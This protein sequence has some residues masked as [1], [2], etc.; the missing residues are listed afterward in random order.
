MVLR[1]LP[2]R[3]DKM[4]KGLTRLVKAVTEH[5]SFYRLDDAAAVASVKNW[6]S[7]FMTRYET[8]S[9]ESSFEKS[10]LLRSEKL[11]NLSGSVGTERLIEETA[12]LVESLS[13]KRRLSILD[14]GAEM[15]M[16]PE[17]LTR[18]AAR[19]VGLEVPTS[20]GDV[21]GE[22]TRASAENLQL[23]L[24]EK[25]EEAAS[26]GIDDTDEGKLREARI[27]A[28]AAKASN[29]LASDLARK[30]QQGNKKEE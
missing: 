18:L 20:F 30:A 8:N 12:F 9:E 5:V 27:H 26:L 13:E 17:Q 10:R 14:A 7:I 6:R 24:R 25:M 22:A 16:S 23:K 4:S 2:P 15:S 29:A 11:N 3:P 19:R 21:S 28:I 1:P